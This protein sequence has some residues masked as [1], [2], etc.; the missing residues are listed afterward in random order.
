M[1]KGVFFHHSKRF[2]CLTLAAAM[3]SFLVLPTIAAAEFIRSTGPTSEGAARIDLS[4][5][6]AELENMLIQEKLGQLG[7]SPEEVQARV[8]SMTPGQRA[9]VIQQLRP[10]R[11]GRENR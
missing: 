6:K 4:T 1:R 3:L 9:E 8:D 7:L 11:W 5:L 10:F 2:L